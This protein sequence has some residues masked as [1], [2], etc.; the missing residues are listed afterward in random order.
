LPQQAD[1]GLA[2]EDPRSAAGRIDQNTIE[3]L[4]ALPRAG[5]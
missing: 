1:I 5:R 4:L 3:T 2:S